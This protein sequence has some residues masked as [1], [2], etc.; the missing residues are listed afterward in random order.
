MTDE[1]LRRVLLV[2]DNDGARRMRALMLLTHGFTVDAISSLRDLD[3]PW[4][5]TRYGLVL[6]SLTSA[7][8]KDMASWKRIQQEH[9]AQEFMFLLSATTRLCPLFLDGDQ[10]RTE[11]WPDSFLPRVQAAFSSS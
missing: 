11:E 2:D 4:E 10:V 9:P 8:R 3:R 5:Q 6:L 1:L 7:M